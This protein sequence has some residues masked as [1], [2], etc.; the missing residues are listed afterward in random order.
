[1]YSLLTPV[2]LCI[3]IL[4]SDNNFIVKFIWKTQL[5]KIYKYPAIGFYVRNN[6]TNYDF[7]LIIL[8]NKYLYLK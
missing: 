1:M 2:F 4:N 8:H 7:I 6:Y 3:I 5:K